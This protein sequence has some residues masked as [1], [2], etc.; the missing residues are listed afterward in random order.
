VFSRGHRARGA[1]LVS[2]FRAN[3]FAMTT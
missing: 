1:G 3:S 2:R